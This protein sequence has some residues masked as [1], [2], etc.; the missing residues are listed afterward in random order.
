MMPLFGPE[1]RE[2][3]PSEAGFAWHDVLAC[4]A[5]LCDRLEGPLLEFVRR[6]E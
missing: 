4:T 1:E 2:R 3:L 6:R 5:V